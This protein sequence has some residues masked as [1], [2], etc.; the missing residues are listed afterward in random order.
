[1]SVIRSLLESKITWAIILLI[2]FYITFI[3]SGKYAS[4]I[5]LKIYISELNNEIEI[6]EEENKNLIKKIDL[7]NTDYHIE[8]IAREEL[9]LIKDNEILYKTTKANK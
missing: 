2:L 4:I 3:F 9:D 1:M 7:L 8:R 5:E 6:L